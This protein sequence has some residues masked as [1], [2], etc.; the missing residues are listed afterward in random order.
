VLSF[1]RWPNVNSSNQPGFTKRAPSVWAAISS[2]RWSNTLAEIVANPE[3]GGVLAGTIRRR[4]VRR[5]PF[6][7]LY[8]TGTENLW[9]IALMHL[10]RRPGYAVRGH[11]VYI[12]KRN[13]RVKT[14]IPVK[15]QK[16]PRTQVG[17]ISD[18]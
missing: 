11:L 15:W 13:R 3:A 16:K 12:A 10:H 14:E 4:L 2:A 18:R 9:V 6:A 7:I 8:Q 1:T 17:S 5:F